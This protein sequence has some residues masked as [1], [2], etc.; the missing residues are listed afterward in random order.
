MQS[1]KIFLFD[2]DDV[3]LESGGYH[4]ALKE[5]VAG[6]SRALGFHQANI[7][8]DVIHRFE[9]AGITAEWD[10]AAICVALLLAR[11]WSRTPEFEIPTQLPLPKPP[12]HSLSAPDFGTFIDTINHNPDSDC[13][14]IQLAE[15]A[16]IEWTRKFSTTQQK[17]IVDILRQ[18]RDINRSIAHRMI[19][20]LNLGSEI[21]AQ[22][23]GLLPALQSE[24]YLLKFDRPL[25]STRNRS[26][27][28]D[29]LE[30]AGN[31]AAIFTN[32][33]SH[34]PPGVFETPE[35]ELGARVAGLD[36]L[37]ILGM[38]GLVW[39]SQKRGR[40]QDYFLK[41]SPV[42]ALAAIQ[43]AIG[44]PRIKALESAASFALDGKVSPYWLKL[45]GSEVIVLEDSFKGILSMSRADKLLKQSSI[46]IHF[47][48]I[49]I[50]T[51]EYKKEALRS[52]G[53]VIFSDVNQA[54][55][56]IDAFS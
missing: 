22:T 31:H 26:R 25:L 32:R 27:L 17:K 47:R 29:W 12:F 41:P 9:A 42:H 30:I 4:R 1:L 48:P 44:L 50:A 46:A 6:I 38:G 16:I 35:A 45:H 19:Q 23:Y 55:E 3:L 56:A 7:C 54:L 13:H 8:D 37:P 21:F 28:L 33:P 18:S 11:V 40:E 36:E 51:N 53:A 20:E 43:R 24:S 2:L 14:S 52:V 15:R 34:P 39:L 5:T 10:S 49:G